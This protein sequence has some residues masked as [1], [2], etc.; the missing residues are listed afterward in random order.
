MQTRDSLLRW[1]LTHPFG[2]D[3]LGRDLLARSVYGL[4]VDLSMI[5][6]A[7]PLGMLAGTAL[8]LGAALSRSAGTIV[9][10][11]LDV[12]VGFPGV[13]LGMYIVLIMGAGRA[14]LVIAIAVTSLP[15]FGRIAR[16]ALL[17]QS[18]REYVTA[19]RTLGVGRRQLV[20]GHILPN[21]MDPILVA[22]AVFVVYAIF[23][24]AGLS[25]VGLDIRPPEP[26]L[27]S[28][29]NQGMRYVTQSPTYVLGP[30]ILLFVLALGLSRLL[31]PTDIVGRSMLVLQNHGGGN[32]RLV[33]DDGGGV[34]PAGGVFD[35][36]DVAGPESLHG[37][38]FEAYL[39]MPGDDEDKLSPRRRMP[40]LERSGAVD[41]EASGRDVYASDPVRRIGQVDLFAAGPPRSVG[42]HAINT[43]ESPP[44]DDGPRWHQGT[45][46]RRADPIGIR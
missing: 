6:I 3:E 29:L 22:G 24:E 41:F 45:L 31:P 16:G 40:V 35:E 18:Q 39:E 15:T 20:L 10:R 4:R 30:T 28:L 26:S 46:A 13:I 33:A 34:A 5:A 44:T 25:I 9:Q 7:V 19:A 2:T 1:S 27:G 12:I 8:G 38:I 23:I 21:T 17:A 11:L 32:A 36:S 14:A 37:S 42:V 43:H